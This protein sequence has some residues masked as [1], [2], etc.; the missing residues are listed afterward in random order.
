MRKKA[1]LTFLLL[2]VISLCFTSQADAF[3]RR[4]GRASCSTGSCISYSVPYVAPY[5]APVVPAVVVAPVV[6]LPAYQ[7]GW[8]E[9]VLDYAAYRDDLLL[10]DKTINAL[11]I[12]TGYGQFTSYGAAQGATNYGYTYQSVKE[13]YGQTDLNTLYQAAARTTQNA[14]SLAGQA[15]T[16]FSSLV[17]QAGDNQAR[18][19]EILAKAQAAAI[20]L[21]AANPQPST[22]TVETIQNN[23]AVQS[24][25]FQSGAIQQNAQQASSTEAEFLAN[26]AKVQDCLQCHGDQNPKGNFR[27]ASWPR[28]APAVKSKY[29]EERVYGQD[30]NKL[31]P[32]DSSGKHVRMEPERKLWL[33]SH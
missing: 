10:Y 33:A 15:H 5:V 12:T 18:V 6:Q 24:G 13:A 9:K 26:P 2:A 17:Q 31:M 21:N 22:R 32:R 1:I 14:Q 16:E 29:L 27:I 30:V 8:K 7:P 19:A 3:L 11:G 4:R 28:L 20:A 25:G 23:G